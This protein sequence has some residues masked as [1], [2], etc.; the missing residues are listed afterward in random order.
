MSYAFLRYLSTQVNPGIVLRIMRDVSAAQ[1]FYLVK[2]FLQQEHDIDRQNRSGILL[3]TAMGLELTSYCSW[4]C[5]GCYIPVEERRKKEFMSFETARKAVEKGL[6]WGIRV[7]SPIGGETI[8]AETIPILD[9]LLSM[10]KKA[11]FYGCTNAEYLALQGNSDNRHG[12]LDRL[13]SKNNF[14]L[15]LSINGFEETN[16]FQR[17]K[18]S[19]RYVCEAADY[20][21]SNQCLF[22]AIVTVNDENRKEVISGEFLDFL[23]K[24]GF[25]FSLYSFADDAPSKATLDDLERISTLKSK[26]I[27]LYNNMFGNVISV[28][29]R[30]KA[31]V[32]FVSKDGFVRTSRRES[33]LISKTPIES[34]TLDMIAEQELWKRRITLERSLIH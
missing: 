1:S 12:L 4:R 5:H 32:L 24:R 6:N 8:T 26:P 15:G 21:R 23:V 28:S 11:S 29:P 30:G 16:D 3:P 22:G 2:N 13:V 17:K 31:R 20:L 25:M 9:P 34:V 7:F 19:F 14:S 10:Y 18:D 33:G 27:F